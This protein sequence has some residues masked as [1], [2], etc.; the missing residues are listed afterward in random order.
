MHSLSRKASATFDRYMQNLTAKF[1]IFLK[2]Y[3]QKLKAEFSKELTKLEKDAS[4]YNMNIPFMKKDFGFQKA[5]TTLQ[6]KDGK[7]YFTAFN[8][9]SKDYSLTANGWYALLGDGYNMTL[10]FQ[11]PKK[12]RTH[13]LLSLFK[14]K[15]GRI[16]LS[17]AVV[18]DGKKTH[19]QLQGK[20]IG[21]KMFRIAKTKAKD[22]IVSYI[23]RK[24]S[25]RELTTA[26]SGNSAPSSNSYN[27]QADALSRSKTGILLSFRS[28]WKKLI[29]AKKRKIKMDMKKEAKK[30]LKKKTGGLLK[31]LKKKKFW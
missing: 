7:I 30:I 16:S 29:L 24:I 3:G 28:K 23:N 21:A 9:N 2:R 8:F 15:D 25:N 18:S 20:T 4:K 27:N 10:A 19:F 26:F 31:G 6:L 11:L 14:N 1:S 22:F 13:E 17:V 12:F 5:E